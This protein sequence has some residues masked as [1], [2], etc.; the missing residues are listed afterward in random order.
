VKNVIARPDGS[1]VYEGAEDNSRTGQ[2]DCL[3]N[4]ASVAQLGEGG[5]RRYASG[6]CQFENSWPPASPL[7]QE[8]ARSSRLLAGPWR[9]PREEDLRST[10]SLEAARQEHALSRTLTGRDRPTPDR[11]AA[12]ITR[13]G[14]GRDL[15]PRPRGYV[16]TSQ[17]SALS[18]GLPQSG[19]F[20]SIVRN[21]IRPIWSGPLDRGPLD[22]G[23]GIRVLASP[24]PRFVLQSKSFDEGVVKACASND[25]DLAA[26]DLGRGLD[27]SSSIH[28][29]VSR[30]TPPGVNSQG[31]PRS[32]R[33]VRHADRRNPG[34]RTEPYARTGSS[35]LEPTQTAKAA[36][37][38]RRRSP[39]GYD[40][41]VRGQPPPEAAPSGRRC[42][43]TGPALKFSD[44]DCTQ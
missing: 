21:L 37:E 26:D 29:C 6:R 20:S 27:S 39:S 10:S 41:P 43:E 31:V 1:I 7:S 19:N 30:P 36:G 24:S 3:R 5:A 9:P 17:A 42:F 28:R 40:D 13:L 33:A 35:P 12:A 44:A 38:R 8:T 2:R 34:C 4:S 32:C 11:L 22:R 16:T 14:R 23:L 15:L 18:G 25:I